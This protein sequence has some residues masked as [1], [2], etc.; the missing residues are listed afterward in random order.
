MEV[1]N[2]D[3]LAPAA[4]YEV[5]P[6]DWTN[7]PVTIRV[8]AAD[9]EPE[10]G[11]AP[12]GVKSI[13][14]PDGTVVEGDAADFTVSANGTYD[15]IV[16]D[17]GGNTATLHAQVGNVDT[18]RPTVDFH[19]EPLDGGDR[20]IITE[21]GKTEY[22]NYDLVMN[23]SAGDVGSGIERYE[24]KAGDGEWTVFDPADAPKFTE[25]QIV[26]IV[27]RVWDVA[28]NV[29]EEKSRDIVLDK[30][31]PTAS[32]TLTPGKDGRVNIN[33]G[34]DGSIC[35]IQSITRPD[36]SVAYGVDTLVFEVDQNGDYDFFVWDRCG[37]LLK[38]TV[39]VDSFAAPVQPKPALSEP[40]E[41]KQE[42]EPEPAPEPEKPAIPVEVSVQEDI[43]ALTLAD[44]TC[45]LL[46]ILFAALVWL[47]G[48]KEDAEDADEQS[49]R[50]D[51]EAEENE[52]RGY[53]M[54]K[55]VNAVLAVLSVVLFFL[56]QPLVWRF[57]FVDW[58]TVL[59]VLLCGT[60]L[61]MLI[62]KRK[63]ENSTEEIDE[64]NMEVRE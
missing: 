20:T 23:A 12:S 8:T 32:H 22:Y 25:E 44:L 19:F 35:G 5:M 64:E 13:T 49:E 11:Y 36:G 14:L 33:L 7:K 59:F 28:G 63:Q 38:Y 21:Y 40:E 42:P 47:R 62:W 10:D 51:E 18:A 56:T 55:T 6:G 24:Y 57:R 4:D 3:L 2:I 53:A 39:L 27:V 29:S 17:N 60:A 9:P 1:S 46:S 37:N 50:M 45:T 61:A 16:T 41:P 31:P 43:R 54:Q 58:W 15:F 26:H 48:K 30:T 52:P 34:T